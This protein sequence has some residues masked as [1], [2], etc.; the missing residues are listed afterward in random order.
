MQDD[1]K[2]DDPGIPIPAWLLPGLAHNG[3][4]YVAEVWPLWPYRVLG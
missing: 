2:K 1:P 3:T 4:K